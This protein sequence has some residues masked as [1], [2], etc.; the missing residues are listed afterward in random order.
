M[1]AAS[2]ASRRARRLLPRS[3]MGCSGLAVLTLLHALARQEQP[4]LAD[5]SCGLVS[6]CLRATPLRPRGPL[7]RPARGGAED[8]AAEKRRIE[9]FTPGE[10]VSGIVKAFVR[11]NGYVVDIGAKIAA[12]LEACEM[13]DGFPL[14]G[15]L[16]KGQ[17]ITARVLDVSKAER[18]IHLTRRSGDLARPPRILAPKRS[19]LGP[20]AEAG[21]EDWFEGV[22][23]QMAFFGVYVRIE[24]PGGGR[25]V[26]GLL[27]KNSF[28]KGFADEVA[29][30]SRVSVRVE[31]LE[32]KN[33]YL[34]MLGP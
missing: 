7:G 23:N 15:W 10:E 33:L 26:E 25:P 28:A 20:F 17:A 13:R 8:A 4:P 1:A 9:D 18:R 24:P 31:K 27:H 21:S 11:N 14:E 2:S 19:D 3:R 29:R 22:V 30:G 5:R 16:Q 34:T 12:H 6:A 32:G